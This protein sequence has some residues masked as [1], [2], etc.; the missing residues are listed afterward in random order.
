[1]LLKHLTVK[2]CIGW[3]FVSDQYMMANVQEYAKEIMC[4]D[5]T[6]VVNVPEFFALE[7][8]QLIQ[9][10][11][12]EEID[13]S[14]ALIAAT[15]WILY[16]EP[17]RK[18]KFQD[19]LNDI[20]LRT[21]S[22]SALKHVM[23]NYGSR[24]ITTPELKEQFI[25]AVLSNVPEWKERQR[26]AGYDVIVLMG[27]NSKVANNK[28][29]MINLMTGRTV[30]KASNPFTY[31][32]PAH[33]LKRFKAMCGMSRG[34]VLVGG[35][36]RGSMPR[37]Y[38]TP[39]PFCIC[40]LENENMWVE[41]KEFPCDIMSA[42]AVCM[43]DKKIF[44]MGG[45]DAKAGIQMGYLLERRVKMDC[46]DLSTNKWT[47]CPEML[48]GM[49]TPIAG[50][51]G[52]CIYVVFSTDPV[53][54]HLRQ[55]SEISLQVFNTSTS[56]WSF[57]ASM[58]DCVESTHGASA[59][60]VGHQLYIVGG[61]AKTCASYNIRNNTWTVL[62]SPKEPHHYGAAVFVTGRIFL[63]GGQNEDGKDS[64][65]IEAYNP[66]TDTW[67]MLSVKLPIA[68]SRHCVTPK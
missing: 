20:N 17:A 43:H 50:C 7:Y 11:T 44:V 30:K 8:H 9:Y 46:L 55:G 65:S 18:M 25:D 42:G 1:M 28:T 41:L 12:W 45:G 23:T 60:A 49:E 52:D 32:V 33:V 24:L 29:W 53:N 22:Q 62:S 26:G 63:S 36:H 51:I 34:A 31:G 5:F 56:T 6:S 61:K 59:V 54:Q 39:E 48:Q 2:N 27:E 38:Y 21:C 13:C 67:K 68:L 47:A 35:A 16:D 58:P 40:Y 14:S 37:P 3:Y 66:G 4:V 15:K 64:D 57:K 19:V 10:M